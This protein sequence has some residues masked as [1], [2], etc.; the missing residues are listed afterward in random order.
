MTGDWNG[1]LHVVDPG[2]DVVVDLPG[3]ASFAV[4]VAFAGDNQVVSRHADGST[5]LWDVSASRLVGRLWRS[6]PF[7][8]F[9][10][11]VDRVEN[12]LIQA[13]AQGMARIPLAPD[14]WFQ[15]VCSRVDRQLTEAE[16]TAI[17]PDLDPGPGC[18]E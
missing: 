14:A 15:A 11:A 18:P 8:P 2:R 4:D 17:T 3:P 5:Y 1:D 13:T 12:D 9:G 7:G 16:I 10:M 6:P